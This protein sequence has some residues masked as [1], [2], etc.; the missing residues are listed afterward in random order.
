M[1]FSFDPAPPKEAWAFWKD[2]VPMSMKE[3][4]RLA[5]DERVKAFVVGGMA[6]ADMLTAMHESISKAI[7]TG[8][9]ITAWKEEIS[10]LFEQNGWK[11]PQPW[12]LDNIFRT[13]IQTAYGVGRYK[14]MMDVV[15]ERP[16]WR[17]SAVNDRRTRLSHAA[18][19]GKVVRADDPFWDKF[20]P[21]NGFRC[22]CTV[23]CLS[24]GEMRRKG[25]KAE[26]IEP[27]QP[28]EIKM[29]NNPHKGRVVPVMPDNHFQNNPGKEYWQAD[30]G[31][32]RA[33]VRQMLLKEISKAC[34][35]EFCGPCEFAQTDCYK[36][37]KRHLTQ[38]DLE[39]LQTVVWAEGEKVKQGFGKWVDGV[40]GSTQGKGELY[41]VGTLPARVLNA[42]EKQPRLAL[43]T[44]D[45]KQLLH[46]ARDVKKSRGAALTADEI[47]QIP[48]QLAMGRW[49]R[50]NEKQNYLMTWIRSGRDWLKIVINLDCKIGSGTTRVANHIITGGVVKSDNITESKGYEEI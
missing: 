42:L 43:V 9:P 27:G 13:N 2:K 45:D 24:D 46:M 22:R 33:D 6:R 5:E 31:R 10:S 47:K 48:E 26:T 3:F 19:H 28:L 32:Y 1:T 41:P 4:N 44:I 34:P 25:Y 17:Y 29:D 40:I 35:D 39:D 8:Q 11:T 18:L 30:T 14:Q 23:S 50:D 15:E 7:E 37:L 49:W 36:R 16:Y 20:Y 38:E 21:P 12:R